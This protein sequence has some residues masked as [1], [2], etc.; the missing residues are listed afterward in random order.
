MRLYTLA[1]LGLTIAMAGCATTGNTNPRN[2]VT[3]TNS[4]HWQ[5]KYQSLKQE[6]AATRNQLEATRTKL[7]NKTTDQTAETGSIGLVPPDADPGE[8][9][10]R[11]VVPAE[12]KTVEERV[13][14][15]EASKQIK[16]IPAQYKTV[17]KRVMVKPKTTKLV[18]VPATYKTVT[19]KVLV[20]PK[21]TKWVPGV[22]G[23]KQR[24]NPITGK[25]MCLIT[26]PAKY[27][28][29]TQ[30]V[31]K[32]PAH[33]KRVTVPAEYKTV[34][35]RKLVHEAYTKVTK[36]PAEYSIVTRRKKVED[37]TIKWSRVVCE[38]N[39]TQELISTVQTKLK[40]K[41]Y[42]PGPIDGILGPR[43]MSAVRAY[44]KDHDLAYSEALVIPYATLEALGIPQP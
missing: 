15:S 33:T 25:T 30:R 34:E 21:H 8:C 3:T 32:T 20:R 19:E 6:L 4:Q 17:T 1:I 5:S 35:V 39:A 36:V 10:A 41:G 12:Y 44:S 42:T 27:K 43:T 23:S 24:V 40:Q 11:V 29:I 28:T 7:Q 22:G 37:A 13:L 18:T 2:Q 14:Q 38:Y 16:T 9:F 26:V 31:V